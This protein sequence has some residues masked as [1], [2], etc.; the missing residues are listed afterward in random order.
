MASVNSPGSRLEV[1]DRFIRDP[2]PMTE[3]KGRRDLSTR[4]PTAPEPAKAQGQ[5]GRSSPSENEGAFTRRRKAGWEAR[6]PA[7][8]SSRLP[9]TK[10]QAI[11]TA[12]LPGTF[13]LLLEAFWD[14]HALPGLL[15]CCA[16]MNSVQS[17][18]F[19]MCILGGLETLAKG[20]SSPISTTQ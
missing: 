8:L 18:F 16:C 12:A 1:S 7:V 6:G 19:K 15:A 11:C 5:G 9:I 4:L 3:A 13:F 10:G 14:P 20:V 2:E 17:G